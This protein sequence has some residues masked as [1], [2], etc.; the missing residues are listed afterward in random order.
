M[1]KF[2]RPKRLVSKYTPYKR[3][4]ASNMAQQARQTRITDLPPELIDQV[5]QEAIQNTPHALNQQTLKALRTTN[6]CFYWGATR[7]L[8]QSISNATK[9]TSCN[10]SNSPIEIDT[11]SCNPRRKS[12]SISKNYQQCLKKDSQ[13]YEVSS[14]SSPTRYCPD[15]SISVAAGLPDT[16]LLNPP[17]LLNSLSIQRGDIF[18]TIPADAKKEAGVVENMQSLRSFNFLARHPGISPQSRIFK[19][20]QHARNLES[21]SLIQVSA[22]SK[23]EM[24]TKT[25]PFIHPD[26]PLRKLSLTHTTCPASFLLPTLRQFKDRLENIE[27][28]RVNLTSGTWGVIYQEILSFPVLTNFCILETGYAESHRVHPKRS[29]CWDKGVERFLK[30]DAIDQGMYKEVV[31]GIGR[32]RIRMGVHGVVGNVFSGLDWVNDDGFVRL[33]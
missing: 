3:T 27:L 4:A 7:L 12:T 33:S 15:L 10:R 17:A 14:S 21:L 32:N 19:A 1:P 11:I 13:P 31:A 2:T 9:A 22:T 16:I 29:L 23:M 20:L 25:T 28:P 6:K 30:Q 24:K 5:T 8:F 26:A 18:T